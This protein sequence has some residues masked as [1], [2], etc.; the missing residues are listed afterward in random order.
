M[1]RKRAVLL[2]ALTAVGL[3]ALSAC[4][5]TA[6]TTAGQPVASGGVSTVAFVTGTAQENNAPGDTGDF[7]SPGSP[8]ADQWVELDAGSAGQL[9]P[10]V[11]NGKGFLLYRF[12]KDTPDPST[13]NCNGDCAKTWPP[14]TI[15][16]GGKVFLNGVDQADVG[17][18]KRQDGSL[19]L[20]VH[21]WALYRYSGDAQPGQTNG[22]GIGGTWFG[23][24]PEGGKAQPGQNTTDPSGVQFQ[25]GTAK[26]NNA[27]P[28]AGDFYKGPRTDDAAMKWVQLTR[29]SAGGL[30]PIVHDAAGRTLYRFDNDTAQPSKS[31]CNG[32][33]AKKWPPVLVKPGSR[34]FVNGVPASKI[35]VITRADGTRQV[36]IGN[37]PVYTF[38]GDTGPGQINGE[39]VGGTWFAVSPTGGKVLP[40]NGAA[41]PSSAPAGTSAP[42]TAPSSPGTVTLGNGSAIL[43][44]GKNFSEPDGSFGVS[45]PGCV[46]VPQPTQ[47]SSIQLSGGPVKLW[48]GPGCTGESKVITASVPDLGAIG[49]DKQVASIRFGDNLGKVAV[50]P[51]RGSAPPHQG[52]TGGVSAR[53][54]HSAVSVSPPVASPARAASATARRVSRP[55][56]VLASTFMPWT[57]VTSRSADSGPAP[58]R[59]SPSARARASAP[60]KLVRRLLRCSWNIPVSSGSRPASSTSELVTRQPHRR[61]PSTMAPMRWSK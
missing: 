35:G 54:A 61:R 30:N 49:F 22:Q 2:A 13:S 38:S 18:L 9:N 27:D 14:V 17:V 32:D 15:K 5:N 50:V 52:D 11:L 41:Q 34:I 48:K 42:S 37:W 59:S 55:G 56:R 57:T 51:C 12:D 26:Q 7:A 39:G 21:G 33:C 23:V 46:P 10:V 40:K 19:Q 29:G 45:G 43:D 20:T 47:V 8:S 24:T 31:N 25:T 3:A 58:G 1:L 28:N 4:G 53:G 6:N 16:P 44:S 36:T 60:A